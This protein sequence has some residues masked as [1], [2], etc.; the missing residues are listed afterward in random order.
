MRDAREREVGGERLW[1]G[2]KRSSGSI[3][4]P[5]EQ[6]LRGLDHLLGS[7]KLQA[8]QHRRDS[9]HEFGGHERRRGSNNERKRRRGRR[10]I[11]R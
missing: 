4:R 2:W 10:E 3:R 9:E 7:S 6:R 11:D 1:L 8:Q 5:S